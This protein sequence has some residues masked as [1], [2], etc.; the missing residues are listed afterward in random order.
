[1]AKL[2][3]TRGIPSSGKSTW[4]KKWV[5]EDP[6]NRVRVN[7]DDLRFM[8]FGMYWGLTFEQEGDVTKAERALVESFL[9][10]GKDVVVDA[11]HLR[12]KYIT[13]W[14][15]I[16]DKLGA[17]LEIEEFYIDL[18]EAVSRDLNRDRVVGAKVITNMYS[19]FLPK[20]KFIPVVFTEDPDP[21]RPYTPDETLPTAIIVDVDGT[22]ARMN[23]RGPYEEDKVSTD[24]PIQPIID[25]VTTLRS[26]VNEVI[27]MS[28]RTDACRLDTIDWLA[29]HAFA[30]SWD[31]I[32]MRKAGDTRPDFITKAELFDTHVRDN[33]NVVPVVDDRASVVNMWRNELG[34]TTLQV[35][36]G[37][38]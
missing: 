31:P 13:E 5:A 36:D 29:T 32:F 6:E 4:A 28:G 17:E 26:T 30:T 2:I 16:S 1:M 23:G 10:S 33:Y 18:A 21:A 37:N 9:R 19:K 14:K 11:T 35:A 15:K 24:L 22:V 3:C 25:L 20:G 7:R 38:F 27:W 12:P 8:L 34:I